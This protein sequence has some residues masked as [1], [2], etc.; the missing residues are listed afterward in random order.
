MRLG[1]DGKGD[2]RATSVA[3]RRGPTREPRGGGSIAPPSPHQPLQGSTQ[4]IA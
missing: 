4:T 3:K 1:S 2:I